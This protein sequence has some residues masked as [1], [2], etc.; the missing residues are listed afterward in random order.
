LRVEKNIKVRL[1]KLLST[2]SYVFSIFVC[3]TKDYAPNVDF[4]RHRLNFLRFS[5][6][7]LD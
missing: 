7:M 4:I 6:S 5:V 2:F 1:L 3:R